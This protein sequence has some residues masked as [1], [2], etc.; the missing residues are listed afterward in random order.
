MDKLKVYPA[1]NRATKYDLLQ[2]EMAD[3]ETTV[4][5]TLKRAQRRIQILDEMQALA[6]QQ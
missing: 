5:D 6:R 3:L 1:T 2:E 4:M